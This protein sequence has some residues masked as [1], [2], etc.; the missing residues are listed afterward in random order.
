MET[1]INN[2]LVA[3]PKIEPL[4][5]RYLETKSLVI[6]EFRAIYNIKDTRAKTE[7][8]NLVDFLTIFLDFLVFFPK[9]TVSPILGECC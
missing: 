4:L 7:Y 8:I 2:P 1:A 3:N 9:W 5:A 6:E